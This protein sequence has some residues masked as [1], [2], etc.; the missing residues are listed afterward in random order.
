MLTG[1]EAIL[2][3][4]GAGQ[5]EDAG[6]IG[7]GEIAADQTRPGLDDRCRPLPLGRIT[8]YPRAR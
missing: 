5:P 3:A 6:Q 1:R 8:K 4:G 2:E 7:R